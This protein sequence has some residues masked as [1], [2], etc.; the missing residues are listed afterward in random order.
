[1]VTQ[2]KFVNLLVDYSGFLFSLLQFVVASRMVKI[3]KIPLN[4]YLHKQD[5]NSQIYVVFFNFFPLF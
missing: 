3:L 1:M 2:W 4:I 5:L